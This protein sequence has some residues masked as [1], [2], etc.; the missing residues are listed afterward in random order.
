MHFYPRGSEWRKWD[1]HVHTPASVLRN[2]FGDDWDKYV[3][4]LFKKAIEN[5]ISAIGIIPIW[6]INWSDSSNL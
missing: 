5:D 4:T 1:L 6:K 2:E 3:V